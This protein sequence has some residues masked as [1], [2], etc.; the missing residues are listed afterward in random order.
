MIH[1]PTHPRLGELSDALTISRGIPTQETASSGQLP[2][3]SVPELRT[4]IDPKRFTNQASLRH[5]KW[6][7]AAEDDVLIAIE[8]AAAGEIF[9]VPDGFPRFVPSQQVAV[10]SVQ[11]RSRLDPWYLGAFLSLTSSRNQMRSLARGQKVQR[12]PLHDLNTVMIS[13]PPLTQ[14]AS[15]G[16]H[17]R[18]YQRAIRAHRE[19]AQYLEKM[20]S[21]NTEINLT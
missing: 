1:D 12:I 4:G 6:S 18:V 7:T 21:S 5:G 19:M 16:H 15:Y 11:D 14:Q 3:Y 20:C 2:V 8:G 13:L 10:I 17:Y 9:V